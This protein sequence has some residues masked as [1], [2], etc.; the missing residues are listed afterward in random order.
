ML[1][2]NRKIFF[3]PLTLDDLL[4]LLTHR[5]ATKKAPAPRGTGASKSSLSYL[6][7]FVLNHGHGFA[8]G[9]VLLQAFGEARGPVHLHGIAAEGT[10]I[11]R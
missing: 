6:F 11:G 4:R 8:D 7:N 1:C 5:N 2:V 10:Y 3:T 9:D